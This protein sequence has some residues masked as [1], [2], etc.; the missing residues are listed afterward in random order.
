MPIDADSYSVTGRLWGMVRDKFGFVAPI[1]VVRRPETLTIIDYRPTFLMFLAFLGLFGSL[2][3]FV[4]VFLFVRPSDF[5][6]YW[7]IGLVAV[8]SLAISFRGTIR[9]VYYFDKMTKS[10]AFSRQFI[11]RNEVIEGSIDQFVGAYVKTIQH[12]EGETYSVM[13]QQ[14]GMFLTGVTEQML[15]DETPIFNS[16]NNEARIANA[17]SSFLPSARSRSNG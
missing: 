11:C 9:E 5:L 1:W 12:E 14:E 17:I 6:V 3:V 10:Y 7:A 13:L 4:Y 15:R 2:C 16:F 8:I